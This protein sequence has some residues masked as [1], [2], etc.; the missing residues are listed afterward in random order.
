MV[1][2]IKIPFLLHDNSSGGGQAFASWS[3]MSKIGRG[4]DVIIT[5]MLFIFNIFLLTDLFLLRSEIFLL[6]KKYIAPVCFLILKITRRHSANIRKLKT[7]V[8]DLKDHGGGIVIQRLRQF[9]CAAW[10]VKNEKWVFYY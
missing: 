5:V 6:R 4:I 8:G 1:I 10:F 2:E 7:L 3:R 9:H